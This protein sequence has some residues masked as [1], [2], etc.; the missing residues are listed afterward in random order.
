MRRLRI[1]PRHPRIE[2]SMF[3]TV[4]RMEHNSAENTKNPVFNRMGNMV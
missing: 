1:A 3:S 4:C 2:I